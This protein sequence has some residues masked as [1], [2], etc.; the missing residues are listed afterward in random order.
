M[1]K[2]ITCLIVLVLCSLTLKSQ[3]KFD[4]E[5][6]KKLLDST[7]I[8]EEKYAILDSLL[9]NR[10]Q[11]EADE[12]IDYSYQFIDI[13]ESRKD[14]KAL[15]DKC[16]KVFYS[17]NN[18]KNDRKASKALIDKMEKYQSKIK[19]SFLIASIYLK[20]GGFYY[21]I[22]NDEAIK[23][24]SLAISNFGIADSIHVA[25]SYL[26]RGQTLDMKGNFIEAIDDYEIATQYYE[27][28]GDIEYVYST[29]QAIAIVY[30][31]NGFSDEASKIRKDIIEYSKK[32][33][34]YRWHLTALANEASHDKKR[35]E[36]EGV[37]E[38][39]HEALQL[40]KNHNSNHIGYDI[41]IRSQLVDYYSKVNRNLASKHLD[42]LLKRK[43]ET[44]D[45][46]YLNHH[47]MFA[48]AVY[49]KEF[50]SLN[51]SISILEKRSKVLEGMQT[52]DALIANK[53]RLA[54]LYSEI[55]NS[56]KA[57]QNLRDYQRLNDSV[58]NLQK[59]NTL[60]YYQK[61]Y[62]TE[63]REKELI[64]K[65]S[66]VELLEQKNQTKQRV[67]VLSITGISLLFL[68]IY[69]IRNR[70]Y[71]KKTK[72]QQEAFS[73]QLLQ[74]QEE[75]RKRISKDLHDSLGQSLLL[76]K[77]KVVLND[78]KETGNIVNNAIEEVRSISRALHPFQLEE[79][80]L[81]K[82]IK[83]VV[84]QLDESTEIFISSEVDNIENLFKPDQEVNIFRIIQESLNNIIKH[85]NAQAAR[86]EIVQ[87]KDQVQIIIKDNGKGFDFSEQYN[88]FKSLG[89][90][91]LKERT[92]LLNGSMKIDSERNKGTTLAFTIPLAA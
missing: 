61:K 37:L 63:R 7:Q 83:N 21:G 58:F 43:S 22:Q 91:T 74:S 52:V 85:S 71:L 46:P 70:K 92:K 75:E 59:T 76:I 35:G 29:K 14:Y 54:D 56:D 89:L 81:T 24:Y 82:A 66:E 23:N 64:K 77:N 53:K 40:N 25:D 80:G 17:V 9:Q 48:E 6:Y 34:N 3:E 65:T 62:E 13:A 44:E 11:L 33:K 16:I 4:A 30:S 27:N 51:K 18:I 86:V 20:K 26:F 10:R 50:G 87:N 32:T 8:E 68:I 2:V 31:R 78:D 42:T 15:I 36:N 19:D 5:Y 90:K 69:L 73:Q 67:L 28:L 1:N 47:L 88:D 84:N 72:E 41:F 12:V 57:Y 38:K 60:L 39:L 79:L 55:G 49:E 45:D